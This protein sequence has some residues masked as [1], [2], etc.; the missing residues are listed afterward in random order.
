MVWCSYCGKDQPTER[1]DINGFTCC[2]G[3]G[4]VLDDNV[5]SS[6]PTFMK[7]AG[8]QSQ[9]AGNFVKEGQYSSYGRVG[10]DSSHDYGFKTDSHEKTLEKGRDEIQILADTLTVSG[11]DDAVNAGHRLY[12]IAVERNFT[13]GRRIKQVAAACLYIVCRQEQKP[14]LLID[15]SDILQINVYVLGA[16]F[17]QL[18]K[19]L[20]LELHPIIQ[21]PVD[22]SLFI[23]RFADRLLGRTAARKQFHA[24]ANTALRILASMKRDW[25]QTGRKPSG[26]CGAALYISALSH[27]FG[28]TKADVVSIVHI[29]EATLTKRLIEFE[30]TESGSLTAEEFETKAKELEAEMQST[31]L[32]LMNP[33]IK[34]IRG[35]AELLCEHKDIGAKHFAHGLCHTCYDEFVKLSGGI[36]GGSAPPAFQ[37]AEQKRAEESSRKS[38]EKTCIFD[39]EDE[40]RQYEIA[41]EQHLEV[42]DKNTKEK[43]KQLNLKKVEDRDTV[44]TEPRSVD[45]SSDKANTGHSCKS[46]TSRD[47]CL[48]GPNGDSQNGAMG[49][50]I[51]ETA[52]GCQAET[53]EWTQNQS[54]G[55]NK[56]GDFMELESLSDIDDDEVEKYLHNDEEVRLKTIIWTEMNK[57]YLEEQ[58]AKEEALAAAQAAHAA[59]LAAAAE[60]SPAAVELAAAAAA[61]VAK[62]KKDKQRKR[63]EESK[64]RVPAQSA[65]EATRQM[66]VKKKLSS[67]VNYDVLE[68][69]FEDNK[70]DGT[71]VSNS[72]EDTHNN[73]TVESGKRPRTVLWADGDSVVPKTS[74]K[75]ALQGELNS[76][77]TE[78]KEEGIDPN[79]EGELEDEDF[80]IAEEDG[81]DNDQFQPYRLQ[82]E[83]EAE[84]DYEEY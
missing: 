54:Q 27:G 59:A 51:S 12:V 47:G 43:E 52:I 35:I 70:K 71:R 76:G 34:G 30:N 29:C 60:G 73:S 18:C 20:R 26:V 80:G 67:K 4:R 33:M 38:Q 53:D 37:R 46:M 42:N 11:R 62:L 75:Q 79:V 44:T 56:V 25:M 69:L 10:G 6:D 5:Y 61:A 48:E 64:N 40:E 78:S 68:K 24:I 82:Y 1:D 28:C 3:C 45:E 81:V 83:H 66:L 23:H 15:F 22:P 31:K 32:P 41:A 65:A 63:A 7:T 8:G 21:K 39:D 58:A 14:F 19:L 36:H 72:V 57:E 55:S 50:C 17:L 77:V 16:V 9:L 74:K 2:T 84:Y 13:R 49:S